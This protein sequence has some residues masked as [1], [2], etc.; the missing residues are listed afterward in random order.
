MSSEG[1]ELR[2]DKDKYGHTGSLQLG[3]THLQVHH[4][5]HHQGGHQQ[6]CHSQ[7]HHQ[8]VGGGLQ[9]PFLQHCHTHQTIAED[10]GQDERTVGECVVGVW[11]GPAGACGVL[12]PTGGVDLATQ[13]AQRRHSPEGE[14]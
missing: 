11:V 3:L 12:R 4:P 8:V 2:E 14:E 7:A 6:V 1:Q 9:S 10:D 5:G 13:Q